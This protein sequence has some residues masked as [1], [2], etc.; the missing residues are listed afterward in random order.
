MRLSEFWQLMDQEFGPAY[1]RTLA[2]GH[3][4]HALGDRTVLRAIEDGVSVR[5]VWTT[6]CDDLQV[7]EER[8]FIA[9]RKKRS[10]T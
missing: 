4:L 5:T 2:A 10:R 3:A 1:A 6:L 7:P 8:R 9:D